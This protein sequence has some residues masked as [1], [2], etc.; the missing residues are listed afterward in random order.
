MLKRDKIIVFAISA[1]VVIFAILFLRPKH[2]LP[3][4]VQ[5]NVPIS[6]ATGTKP[7]LAGAPDSPYT[8]V[9]FGDYE[10]LPCTSI[11]S[12]VSRVLRRNIGKMAFQF[13]HLPLTNM[14]S[15]AEKAAVVAET[16]R[17]QGKFWEMHE[18]L[19]SQQAR[20]NAANLSE[21]SALGKSY[22]NRSR[23]IVAKDV[24]D[25]KN[26][27]VDA[28]PTFILCCP[29]GRVLRLGGLSQVEAFLQ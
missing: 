9:E 28:T 3:Q 26:L 21:L 22:H 11:Q 2:T 19:Y 23:A 24:Q 8:L 6:L 25:A 18:Y 5:V 4:P 15:M 29:D 12:E 27:G 7:N 13:R 1:Q 20:L 17:I 14:H 10:C 16:A